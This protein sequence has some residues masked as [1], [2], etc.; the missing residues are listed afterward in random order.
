[1]SY[2]QKNLKRDLGD[3]P[4]SQYYNETTDDFEPL[5]GYDG[6]IGTNPFV[7]IDSFSDSANTNKTYTKARSIFL[8]NDGN[9][10]ITLAVGALN[11]TIKPGEVFDEVFNPFT[12]LT[13]TTTVAFRCWVRG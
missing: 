8:S 3:I 6:R 2:D 5:V 7:I 1:M 10:D 11:F 13:V 4:V 12:D 9:A